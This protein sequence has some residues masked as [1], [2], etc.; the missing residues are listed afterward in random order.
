MFPS[1]GYLKDVTGTYLASFIVTG[2]FPILGTLVMAT[3]PHYFSC[4]EPPPPPKRRRLGDKEEASQ[5]EME[6]VNESMNPSV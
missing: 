1:P 2:S 3:L 4:T 6:H 5:T